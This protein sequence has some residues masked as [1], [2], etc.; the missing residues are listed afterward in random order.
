MV[1]SSP[2]YAVTEN[3][4]IV[5]ASD[6]MRKYDI[7]RLPVVN[8]EGKVVGIVTADI[9]AKELSRLESVIEHNMISRE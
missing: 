8:E 2:V 6:T 7:R 4:D 3:T 1:M 9:I 5:E